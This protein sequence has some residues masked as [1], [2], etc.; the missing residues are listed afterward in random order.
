[1]VLRSAQHNLNML[2][3]VASGLVPHN[4]LGLRAAAV[5]GEQGACMGNNPILDLPL[6]EVMR[7]EIALQLQQMLHVHTV[8]HLLYS[9][10]QP[11]I[12]RKIEQ[13][14]DTPEQARHAVAVCS[15]WLGFQSGP[16]PMGM[17]QWWQPD[18]RPVAEA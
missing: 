13:I 5:R 6:T 11:G 4:A 8:G 7:R 18:D 16:A 12:Q 2:R 1:M 3:A 10:R 9:W 14:F 17:R 15:T